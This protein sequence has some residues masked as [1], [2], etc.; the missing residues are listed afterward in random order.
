MPEDRPRFL[1]AYQHGI[2]QLM[3]NESDTSPV[4]CRLPST[5]IIL[6]RWAPDGTVFAVGGHQ[7]DLPEDERNV[8]HIISA[9]GVKL[10]T[11]KLPP[12]NFTGFS[13]QGNGLRIAIVIDNNL[14]L[15]YIKPGYKVTLF[16]IKK[17]F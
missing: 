12:K 8:M 6:C 10:Q 5:V 1:V 13:W 4:I 11:L 7:T 2:I 3:R 14:Y 17:M 16:L 9:Y 15:A